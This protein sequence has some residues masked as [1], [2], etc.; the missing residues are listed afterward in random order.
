VRLGK[1]AGR[2]A[3]LSAIT[4]SY[5]DIN[6]A[7]NAELAGAAKTVAEA[8]T[9]LQGVAGL[10]GETWQRKVTRMAFQAMGQELSD[11]DLDKFIEEAKAE[12]A[13]AAAQQ[14]AQQSWGG[15]GGG[16][17]WGG[18][19]AEPAPG[20]NGNGAAAAPANG[21]GNGDWWSQS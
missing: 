2:E 13:K 14:Q 8:F 6:P 21:N 16:G 18:G 19:A 7:D 11:E 17:G 4:V 10:A 9:A 1:V 15:G 5:P 20:G 12:T 3:E